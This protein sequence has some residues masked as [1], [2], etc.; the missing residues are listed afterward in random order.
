MSIGKITNIREKQCKRGECEICIT[1]NNYE[2]EEKTNVPQNVPLNVPQNVPQNNGYSLDLWIEEQ[3]KNN[4]KITTEEL[5]KLCNKTSKTIKR[6][7]SQ[8]PHIVYVGR[9]SNGH[10]EITLSKKM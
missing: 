3:I 9:G 10:W 6:H 2:H 4:P 7:I 1:N 8:L 5:A